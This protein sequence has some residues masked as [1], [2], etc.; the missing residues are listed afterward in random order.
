MIDQ[1][2]RSVLLPPV[3]PWGSLVHGEAARFLELRLFLKP[4]CVYPMRG[5]SARGRIA[6]SRRFRAFCSWPLQHFLS[7]TLAAQTNR[8]EGV[9]ILAILGKIGLSAL[10]KSFPLLR[11]GKPIQDGHRWPSWPLFW[12]SW[13][14]F[15]HLGV[16]LTILASLWPSWLQKR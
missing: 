8:G 3:G 7:R 9:A 1:R 2:I 5:G 13:P 15:G 4:V 6:L 10:S 12:P 11:F 14:L 16:S